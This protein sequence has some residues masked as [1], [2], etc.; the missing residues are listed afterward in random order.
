MTL[1]IEY[2]FLA[3][4]RV[5]RPLRDACLDMREHQALPAPRF[6]FL[7]NDH[8]ADSFQIWQVYAVAL[9]IFF[10]YAAVTFRTIRGHMTKKVFFHWVSLSV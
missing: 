10:E 5:K 8:W 3:T 7:I 2:L 1:N 6:V 4:S 9:G